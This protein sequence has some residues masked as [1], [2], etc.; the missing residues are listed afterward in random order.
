[1]SLGEGKKGEKKLGEGEGVIKQGHS[2]LFTF[3]CE[4]TITLIFSI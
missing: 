1:V 3:Y 2:C 4:T